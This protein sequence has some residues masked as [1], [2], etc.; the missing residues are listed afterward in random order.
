MT[1]T[2]RVLAG[3]KAV[4]DYR[5]AHA[6]LHHEVQE[7]EVLPIDHSQIMDTLLSELRA[8]GFNS[9]DE[10]MEF[11]KKANVEVVKEVFVLE[12]KCDGC[13][14][15][16]IGCADFCREEFVPL[17]EGD[18]EN[19]LGRKFDLTR[20]ATFPK[21]GRGVFAAV[22]KFKEYYEPYHPAKKGMIYPMFPTCSINVKIIKDAK[23]DTYWE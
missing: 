11:S 7:G 3:R 10:F 21:E 2:E 4:D 15:R 17:E 1:E 6:E 19:P 20:A 23:I 18:E 14:G 22:K 5:A 13:K 16:P 12:G 9:I 8:L